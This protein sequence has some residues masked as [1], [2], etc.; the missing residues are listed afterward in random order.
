MTFIQYYII[1][2]AQIENAYIIT[3]QNKDL[4]FMIVYLEQ[5]LYYIVNTLL[6][7]IYIERYIERF[8]THERP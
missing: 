5:K 8:K 6:S 7:P 4:I 3:K 2:N 1:T